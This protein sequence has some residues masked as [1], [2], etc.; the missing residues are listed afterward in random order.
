MHH[1]SFPFQTWRLSFFFGFVPPPLNHA[2]AM[3]P[4][5]VRKPFTRHKPGWL[6]PAVWL[7]VGKSRRQS[8][9]CSGL[10]ATQK[11]ALERKHIKGSETS[12]CWELS[13]EVADEAR[14][15]FAAEA[16]EH[17]Q[18]RWL[19]GWSSDSHWWNRDGQIGDPHAGSENSRLLKQRALLLIFSFTGNFAFVPHDEVM[20]ME[21]PRISLLKPRG[22]DGSSGAPRR[23]VLKRASKP[24]ADMAL[25]RRSPSENQEQSEHGHCNRMR[26]WTWI[27]FNFTVSFWTVTHP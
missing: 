9:L 17:S 19:G 11:S 3:S 25:N 1:A 16:G 7:V 5:D 23:P 4:E 15:R 8:K 20:S 13:S 2:T 14:A 12:K 6:W 22:A 18:N 10:C 27:L 26:V 21:R 24:L